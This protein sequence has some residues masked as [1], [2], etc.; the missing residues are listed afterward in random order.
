MGVEDLKAHETALRDGPVLDVIATECFGL[1]GYGTGRMLSGQVTGEP[2][3]PSVP[4]PDGR[5]ATPIV[6]GCDACPRGAECWQASRAAA[7]EFLPEL[8]G[9]LDRLSAEGLAGPD[10]LAGWREAT[11][12]GDGDGSFTPPPDLLLESIHL[13]IGAGH[14]VRLLTEGR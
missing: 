2:L 4:G 5:P 6:G 12:Q 11:G 14:T 13:R 9:E 3:A 1:H 7:R 10:L 8:M